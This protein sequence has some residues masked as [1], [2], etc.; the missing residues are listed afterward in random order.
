MRGELVNND[1]ILL[2]LAQPIVSLSQVLPDASF[3]LSSNCTLVS[4]RGASP[5][6]SLVYPGGIAIRALSEA[7]QCQQQ[8]CGII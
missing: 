7:R 6:R 8:E 5:E 1:L 4:R 2:A 3:D